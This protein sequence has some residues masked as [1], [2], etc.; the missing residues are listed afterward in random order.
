MQCLLGPEGIKKYLT[1]PY[2]SPLFG[3]LTGL[4]PLLIQAGDAEVLRDEITLLAHKASLAGVSVE[5]EIFEDCVHV[6]Q[7]FLFLEASRKALQSIRHFVK[8]KLPHLNKPKD[9]NFAEIDA[10]IAA[11]AHQ[12]NETG[13]A[14]PTSLPSSPVQPSVD[15]PPEQDSDSDLMSEDTSRESPEDSP[16]LQ[17]SNQ[18]E[19]TSNVSSVN[20]STSQGR[21]VRPVLRA[22]ASARDLGMSPSN[23]LEHMRQIVNGDQVESSSAK[24]DQRAESPVRPKRHRHNSSGAVLRTDPRPLHAKSS[25]HPDLRALLEDYTQRGPRHMTRMYGPA[26]GPAGPEDDSDAKMNTTPTPPAPLDRNVQQTPEKSTPTPPTHDVDEADEVVEVLGSRKTSRGRAP[27][28][29]LSNKGSS[30][31]S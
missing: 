11:D 14:D 26:N 24:V 12:V 3:D 13:V 31:R 9:V 28:A 25:S 20:G 23:G 7:A 22:Y 29:S 1:H 8:Y 6:F 30:P 5:H 19:R 15:L 2:V 16:A 18:P 21:S 17:E 4:P 27:S 10:D